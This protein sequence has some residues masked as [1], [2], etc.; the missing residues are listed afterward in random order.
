MLVL[1][2]LSFVAGRGL[3]GGISGGTLH[4]GA[5][6][7]APGTAG[8]WWMLMW[9]RGHDIGLGSTSIAPV[10]SMLLGAVATP[11]WFQPGLVVTVLMLFA[12]PLAGLSAHRLG[13]RLTSRR[14]LR[15]VW[16]VSY[17]LAVVATG[18]IAQ[19][20]IGTVVAL[21]VLPIVVNTA[22]QLVDAPGWQLGLVGLGLLA[23][24]GGD[25]RRAARLL[26]ALTP[27]DLTHLRVHAPNY[28]APV[29]AALAAGRAAL[30]GAAFEAIVGDARDRA[31][32][33]LAAAALADAPAPG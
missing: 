4:G 14:G 8:D 33:D 19:G 6:P 3:F 28:V 10:F 30:G 18:A 25:H 17:A 21:V 27:A 24:R 23:G 12:V 32:A 26:G 11:F 29:A 15:I 7:P 5:L 2:G 31:R 20:R 9:E 1:I 16:A 22:G 13:R